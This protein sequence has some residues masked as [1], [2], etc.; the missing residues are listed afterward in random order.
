M[1]E[2]LNAGM[3]QHILCF[4]FN[5]PTDAGDLLPAVVGQKPARQPKAALHK[6][7]LQVTKRPASNPGL[8]AGL[9]LVTNVLYMERSI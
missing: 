3:L 5:I 1:L 9:G 4:L 6:T 8:T 7:K 2:A